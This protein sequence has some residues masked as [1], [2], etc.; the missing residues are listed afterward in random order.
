MSKKKDKFTKKL[1]LISPIIIICLFILGFLYNLSLYLLSDLRF[2]CYWDILAYNAF[3]KSYP[4][5]YTGGPMKYRTLYL[6]YFYFIWY[7]FHQIHPFYIWVGLTCINLI[8]LLYILRVIKDFQI[9]PRL[10]IYIILIFSVFTLGRWGNIELFVAAIYFYCYKKTLLKKLTIVDLMILS[11]ISFKILSF[12][13]TIFILYENRR[14]YF[15]N[16]LIIV[17]VQLVLNLIFID[18]YLKLANFVFIEECIKNHQLFNSG[19]F[20][21]FIFL[22]YRISFSIPIGLL[23]LKIKNRNYCIL[24]PEKDQENQKTHF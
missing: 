2:S 19:M 21:A 15:R 20:L 1:I 16:F 11:F 12:V 8:S 9:I 10:F 3:V 6:P 23:I 18:I 14:D 17:I 22:L 7:P 24:T 13:F 5:L 4:N